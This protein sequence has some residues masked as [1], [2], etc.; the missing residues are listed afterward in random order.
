MEKS[1]SWIRGLG[2]RIGSESLSRGPWS[3]NHTWVP[4]GA[5]LVM[6]RWAPGVGELIQRGIRASL[7]VM[8]SSYRTASEKENPTV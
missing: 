7:R 8:V 1:T 5:M 4:R 2:K 3:A 6:G